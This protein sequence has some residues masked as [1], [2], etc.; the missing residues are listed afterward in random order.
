MILGEMQ[1]K[2]ASEGKGES[3]AAALADRA[4]A[5]ADQVNAIFRD[6]LQ[7]AQ[8]EGRGRPLERE[9]VDLGQLATRM[10]ELYQPVAEDAS[11]VLRAEPPTRAVVVSGH[12]DLLAQALANLIENAIRYAPAG[13]T[14]DIRVEAGGTSARLTVADNGPGIPADE[15]QNV[16]RRL[17]RL[18]R[19]SAT[20]GY[21]LGLALV[22]AIAKAHG[23][24]L[25]LEDNAPGLRVEMR[26]PAGKGG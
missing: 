11:K 16:R 5:E 18:E 14:I 25:D 6:L 2:L 21:G 7:V 15:R 8:L 19:D 4:L 24:T 22:A 1:A 10:F 17:Y 26:F 12:P 13:S 23:A 20:P 9:P 3:E